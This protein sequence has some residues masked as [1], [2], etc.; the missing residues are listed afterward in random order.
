MRKAPTVRYLV[1][2]QSREFSVT[3]GRVNHTEALGS[4]YNCK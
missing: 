4:G 1:A 3:S 2:K